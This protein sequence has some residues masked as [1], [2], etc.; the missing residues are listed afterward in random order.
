MWNASLGGVHVERNFEILNDL[1]KVRFI[2]I[3]CYYLEYQPWTIT[4]FEYWR[5]PDWW[6]NDLPIK[7]EWIKLNVGQIK[8]RN[9]QKHTRDEDEWYVNDSILVLLWS[10][11]V[12]FTFHILAKHNRQHQ[13]VNIGGNEWMRHHGIM[14]QQWQKPWKFKEKWKQETKPNDKWR[15]LWFLVHNWRG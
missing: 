2:F 15:W 11:L 1:L 12:R 9:Q 14:S 6:M 13:S 5:L 10:A 4:A 3:C 8:F 7:S